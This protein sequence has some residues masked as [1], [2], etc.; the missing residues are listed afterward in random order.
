MLHLLRFT[1]T[2]LIFPK[3]KGEKVIFFLHMQFQNVPMKSGRSSI[4]SIMGLILTAFVT[5]MYL[6]NKQINYMLA[7]NGTQSLEIHDKAEKVQDADKTEPDFMR[8]N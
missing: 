4:A 7:H 3:K 6:A 2:S 1:E 8:M 5:L